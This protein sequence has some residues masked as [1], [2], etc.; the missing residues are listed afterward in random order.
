MPRVADISRN[1]SEIMT[2][3]YNVKL[4]NYQM[5][6]LGVTP[7]R[8]AVLAKIS[9]PTVNVALLGRLGTLRLLRRV[10]DTLNIKWEFITNVD[11]PE[12]QFHLAVLTN[13]E[14]R[15]RSVKP[16]PIRVGA[17]RPCV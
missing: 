14:R 1:E 16:R 5:D 6:R 12:D 4:I 3:L 8:L 2:V 17:S 7:E 15:G 13:G 10:T 11:L 9:L